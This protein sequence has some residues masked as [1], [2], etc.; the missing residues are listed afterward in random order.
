VVCK[1]L[2]L[3][4][5]LIMLAQVCAFANE[6]NLVSVNVDKVIVCDVIGGPVYIS[7]VGSGADNLLPSEHNIRLPSFNEPECKTQSAR[8]ID[9]QNTALWAKFSLDIPQTMLNDKQP[10]SVY[11]S[12][13]TSSRVYFNG[14]YLGQN[15][16]PSLQ[17]SEE[18]PGKIDAMFYVPPSLIKQYNNHIVILFSSHH[19][20]LKLTTPINFIGFGS[21]AGTSV[22]LQQ[23]FGLSLL[24]LG[25]LVLGSV[26]FLVASFSPLNRQTNILLML[27]CTLAACQLFTEI[28]RAL[29][30]YS[31]PLH[32]IRLLLIATFSWSFGICL[33]YFISIKLELSKAHL[34]TTLG[35]LMSLMCVYFV[36]GFDS[37]TAVGILA[38]SFFCAVL[39]IH[40][41]WK[42]PS[43]ALLASLLVVLALISIVLITLSRFHDILF[44]YIIT[45]F[46]CFLFIQQ[47]L[48]LNKEQKQ[49]KLE[50]QQIAKLQF[51][52]EQNQQQQ[53]PQK[54]SINSA[55]KTDLIASEKIVYCKA[56]GD[57]VELYLDQNKQILYSG[58]LKELASQ[59]PTTFLRVHRSYL[60]NMDYIHSLSSTSNKPQVLATG[61][62]VLSL[63]G[64]YEVP[65]SR[66]IMPQVR[67]LIR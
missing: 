40:K 33:I 46:L 5:M 23:S 7:A 26:Y 52:L 16:T 34:W 39:I 58:N 66:R 59:L 65:V 31:Y 29:F 43:K 20:F 67:N 57:Y 61:G 21:Y 44:Y 17:A 47:A 6:I 19:G 32:D 50:Q 8:E 3:I 45:A 30:S 37:K 63:K 12:G 41:L 62:G 36:P 51:K 60:V 48:K 38:P 53:A 9:P 22:I 10:L 55:G 28:S 11:V 25:A 2:A 27:M 35:G 1:R 15:G 4:V 13:K 64:D 14:A 49:R 18:F 24:P 54:I 42:R 56:A